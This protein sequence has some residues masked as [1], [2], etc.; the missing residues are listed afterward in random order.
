M[1][2]RPSQTGEA[3]IWIDTSSQFDDKLLYLLVFGKEK[4][5][6]SA[7]IILSLDSQKQI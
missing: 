1:V 7:C 6:F 4:M 3:C 5:M 2:D